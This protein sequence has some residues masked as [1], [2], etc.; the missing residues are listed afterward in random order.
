LFALHK[1]FCEQFTHFNYEHLFIKLN[2]SFHHREVIAKY[3][4]KK[5]SNAK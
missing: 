5:E 3:M 1:D 4:Q 2:F